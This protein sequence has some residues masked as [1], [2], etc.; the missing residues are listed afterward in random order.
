MARITRAAKHLTHQSTPRPL[1]VLVVA[2]CF[3]T[4]SLPSP[5]SSADSCSNALSLG[6][7]VPFNTTGLTC[8]QAWPSQDFIL[9][10]GKAASGSNVWS[11]V[12]SAPDNGGYISVGFSPT[13][14]MVGSS[15]VA[16]WVTAAGAG[17]A[18]QYY[19]GGT[20]SSS[21]PPDQGKLAL[22]RG[23]A[24]PTIVSKGSRLYLA[25][26][27]AGQ[28][29]T[30]V[31]YAVGPSGSLPGSNGLLPQHQDMASGTISLSGGSS[32]GGSP[33]TGGGD[34][35][36]DGDGDGEGEEGGEGKKSK[37][38]GEDS[39]DGDDEGKGERR[40]SPASASSSGDNGGGAVLSSKRRHGVLAVVGWGVL[41]PAGVA[42]AR[43][44]KRL[45]PF[46]FY[47]H[48]AAQ[49]LGCVVGV[50][51]VVAGFKLDDADE[52]RFAAHKA[53]GIAVVVGAVLQATAL[54]ARP[55]KDTKA[56]RYWNW[57]HHNVGR[58]AVALGVANIFYGLSL[59][60]ERQEWSY[61]Y[62]IFVGILAVVF[63]VLEEWRRNH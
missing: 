15:A 49:G 32:G 52:G 10:F 31:V 34:G 33:A 37:R 60:N 22:A 51:A 56:R 4:L 38:A 48:V 13:G 1:P 11:F 61:V 20:S 16:G 41:V 39:G 35:D 7:L 50:V 17:S 40:T 63:L 2:L 18:R 30:G 47:A 23:A 59:A 28:P 45:D 14:R 43:F 55:A 27:L 53:I 8:F 5:V 21:C 29:L 44:F 24:A 57:Y 26:Q 6:S 36:G 42:L 3:V 9:R 62:G 54:L 25:F 58:A 19:L 46:W 12:L